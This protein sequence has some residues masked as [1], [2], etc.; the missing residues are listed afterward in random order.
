MSIYLLLTGNNLDSER[1][2]ETP[3][4]QDVTGGVS[5]ERMTN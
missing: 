1:Q 5:L 2:T 3:A 4:A